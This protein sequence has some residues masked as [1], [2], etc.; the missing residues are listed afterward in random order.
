M[1]NGIV[2]LISLWTGSNVLASEPA[3][4]S[5]AVQTFVPPVRTEVKPPRYPHISWRRG[6]EGWVHLSYMVD[7]EGVPYDI[8]VTA[9][10]NDKKFEEAAIRAVEKWRYEPGRLGETPIDAGTNMMV[11]F[12]LENVTGANREFVRMFRKFTRHIEERD[13][14]AA[15]AV[16]GELRDKKRRLYEEAYYHLAR[17]QLASVWG[18]IGQ[19]HGA[20]VR[21]T[22][23]DGNRGFLPDDLQTQM[24]TQTLSLELELNLIADANRTAERLL[25]RE[26]DAELR[27]QVEG[28]KAQIKDVQESGIP[29]LVSETIESSNRAYYRLT[30]SVFSLHSIVGDVAEL[31]LHCD[32]G[33]VGFAFDPELTYRVD[34]GWQ[35]CGLSVIGSPGTH[36]VIKDGG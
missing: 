18:T 7:P 10:S 24:L 2:L 16:L 30:N 31:R 11:T 25:G 35:H 6:N 28:V 12:E 32:K 34:P 23:M 3:E 21:A 4:G 22:A 5:V 14:T 9:S 19:Q 33:Y 27:R 17:Y 26:I 8:A 20:L 13:R 15:Q 36:F 29:F 1:R